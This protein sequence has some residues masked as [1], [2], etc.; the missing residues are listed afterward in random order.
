VI[1][2]AARNVLGVSARNA[3]HLTGD[4]PEYAQQKLKMLKKRD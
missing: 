4:R 2:G 3:L 1:D